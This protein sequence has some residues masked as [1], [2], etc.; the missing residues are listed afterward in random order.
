[1]KKPKQIPVKL[2]NVEKLKVEL[3]ALR[4]LE[5]AVRRMFTWTGWDEG[6]DDEARIDVDRVSVRLDEVEKVRSALL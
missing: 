5:T 1:M 4:Q 3:V 6:V 2:D